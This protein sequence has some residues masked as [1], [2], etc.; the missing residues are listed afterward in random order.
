MN[1][2]LLICGATGFIGR[3][4]A[5]YFVKN[6]DFA[7]YATYF[8]SKPWNS[9][10]ITWLQADLNNPQDVSNVVSGMDIVLQAAATTSGT[11]D[12]VNKPYFHVTDNAVMNSLLLRAAYENS[13]KHVVFFSC[14]IMYSSCDQP[15]KENNFDAN[16]EMHPNYFGA[17]WTKIY[18]EKMCEFYARL[19]R[20]KHTVIRHSNIYGAHDKFDLEK[21]HVF[22]ATMTKVLNAN[23]NTISIWGNGYEE[24]DLL[25]VDDLV[26]FVELA[27]AKQENSFQLYNAGYGSSISVKDLAKKIINCANKNLDIKY[28]LSQPSTKT[29]LSLDCSKAKEELGWYPKHTLEEGIQKTM[30]WYQINL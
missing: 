13:V 3:N 12:I 8:K 30:E 21:S 16:L 22:G 28:D 2:N 19:G 9:S 27:I 1:Q 4:L 15:L 20:T 17:G 11:K 25:Y 5:E 10:K 29:K 7:V 26:D 18:I 6:K 14:T 23:D 24:R